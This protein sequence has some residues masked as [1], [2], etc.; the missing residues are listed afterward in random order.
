MTEE[1]KEDEGAITEKESKLAKDVLKI[2]AQSDIRLGAR[3]N[4]AG[5]STL[6]KDTAK[7]ILAMYLKADICKGD[8]EVLRLLMVQA[9]SIAHNITLA[10]VEFAENMALEKLWGKHPDEVTLNDIDKMMEVPERLKKE[11]KDK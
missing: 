10:T 1:K 2:I 7:R 4:M 8:M 3:E 5:E 6:Y 9:V 11:N